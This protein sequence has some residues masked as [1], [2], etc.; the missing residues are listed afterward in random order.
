M[1]KEGKRGEK[2]GRGE[3]GKEG[4][5]EGGENGGEK[6]FFPEGIGREGFG[7]CFLYFA[8]T[9]PSSSS[10]LSS[11]TYFSPLSLLF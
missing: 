11:G 9:Y 1:K 6:V 2:G 4:G 3:K 5:K 8:L 10:S 7:E